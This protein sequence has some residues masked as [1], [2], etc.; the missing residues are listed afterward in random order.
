MELEAKLQHGKMLHKVENYK[1]EADGILLYK[2]RI[3]VPNVQYLKCMILHEI[4]NF[5]Y[6]GHPRYQKT[7]ATFNSHYFWLGMKK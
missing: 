2:K 7:V 1:L 4:H 3:Y 5:P 6:V